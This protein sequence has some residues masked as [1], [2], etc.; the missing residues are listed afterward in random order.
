MAPTAA[1]FRLGNRRPAQQAFGLEF[2][3]AAKPEQAGPYPSVK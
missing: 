2:H 1:D 3:L